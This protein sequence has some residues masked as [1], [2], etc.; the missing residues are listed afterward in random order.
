MSLR[1]LVP[2]A[3]RRHPAWRTASR[4]HHEGWFTAGR[5]VRVWRRILA[6][7]PTV[8]DPVASGTPV[9]VHLMCY[10]LDHLAAIWALK[11]FYR[12]A[13]ARLP[14]VIHLQ[15][16]TPARVRRRLEHHFPAARVISQHE[17]DREVEAAL[18]KLRLHRLCRTRRNNP[19]IMKLTDFVLIGS[20]V[21]VLALDSDVLFFERPHELLQAGTDPMRETVFM[22]D[23]ASSYNVSDTEAREQ[24]GITL[25]PR[26]NCGVMLFAR[27]A[28]V[29]GLGSKRGR[30]GHLPARALSPVVRKRWRTRRRGDA[31][32]RG[33]QPL[34]LH[35][36]RRRAAH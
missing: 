22:H 18:T 30:N 36:G 25:V 3:V 20:S 34:P 7:T 27:G 11:S 29:A 26:I 35:K 16:H 13:G 6:S 23:L 21:H 24:F 28:D 1:R 8:T 9:E 4:L 31:A 19:M 12:A 10:R 33:R 14:L 32:L 17:A 15:G 5:R 2:S